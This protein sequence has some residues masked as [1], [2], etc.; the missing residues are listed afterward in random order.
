LASLSIL[1]GA[2]HLL[3]YLDSGLM[4]HL[5][6]LLLNSVAVL[7]G[8]ASVRFADAPAAQRADERR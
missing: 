3:A 5:H 6:W 4:L 2:N 7:A 1:L 8:F